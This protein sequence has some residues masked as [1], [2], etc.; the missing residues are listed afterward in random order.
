MTYLF[1][2]LYSNHKIQR[3]TEASEGQKKEKENKKSTPKQSSKLSPEFGHFSQK[4]PHYLRL[5]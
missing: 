4:F 3:E 1:Q 2:Q 5:Y